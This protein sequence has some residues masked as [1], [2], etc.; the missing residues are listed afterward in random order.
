MRSS[1][2]PG[3]RGSREWLQVF[4]RDCLPLFH[5]VCCPRVEDAKCPVFSE[6]QRADCAGASRLDAFLTRAATGRSRVNERAGAR[7]VRM[8]R[9]FNLSAPRVSDAFVVILPLPF[10]VGRRHGSSEVFCCKSNLQINISCFAYAV[11]PTNCYNFR[12][13]SIEHRGGHR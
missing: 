6:L 13:V 2:S 7:C 5:V 3:G 9:D 1:N 11:L 10:E 12:K 8:K 4:Q